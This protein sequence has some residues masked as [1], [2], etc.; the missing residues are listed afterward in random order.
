MRRHTSKCRPGLNADPA[1]RG[2]R[3]LRQWLIIYTLR[4]TALTEGDLFQHLAVD[5]QIRCGALVPRKI[6]PHAADL[7]APPYLFVAVAES[8]SFDSSEQGDGVQGAKDEAAG[9]VIGKC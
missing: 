3:H 1:G 6:L 8:C 7:Q 9:G 5:I 2:H 4:G